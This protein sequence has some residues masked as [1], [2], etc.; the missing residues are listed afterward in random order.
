MVCRISKNISKLDILKFT[1]Q[2]QDQ[3]TKVWFIEYNSSYPQGWHL[4]NMGTT[5]IAKHISSPSSKKVLEENHSVASKLV[6][7]FLVNEWIQPY[8]FISL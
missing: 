4:V 2:S 5:L 1:Q 8:M 3:F 7:Q 6:W